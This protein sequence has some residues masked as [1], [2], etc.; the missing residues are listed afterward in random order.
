MYRDNKIIGRCATYTM[1]NS[2]VIF[3]NSY[4][5]TLSPFSTIMSCSLVILPYELKSLGN[6][7]MWSLAL[8][9]RI[10]QHETKGQYYWVTLTRVYDPKNF[11]IDSII[12]LK[13]LSSALKTFIPE[14][15]K[16]TKYRDSKN[17]TPITLICNK[18]ENCLAKGPN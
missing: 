11:V 10:Q 1:D 18:K 15:S 9:A 17:L 13:W 6:E 5:D 12:V 14:T 3:L 16:N 8:E 4:M 7:V 2:K